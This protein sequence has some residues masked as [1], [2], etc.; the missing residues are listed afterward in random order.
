ML[1]SAQLLD[2][3]LISERKF[4]LVFDNSQLPILI[5]RLSD[6]KIYTVITSFE[7]LFGYSKKE[8]IDK[9]TLEI[10]LWEDI[11]QRQYMIDQMS[12]ALRV[13]DL[14]AVLITKDGRRLICH[15]SCNITQI[16]GE[17]YILNDVYDVTESVHLLEDLKRM[18]THD[19]LTGLAN[20][21]LFY[22]RFDQA[23]ALA[24]RHRFQLAIVMM[25][26]DKLK[27]T[28]DLYGHLIGD[29]A[30]IYLTNQI[31][32]VLRKADTFAR[33]GGDE[34]CIILNEV[35][36]LE[37]IITVVDRIQE[38]LEVPMMIDEVNLLVQVSMGIAVY[39]Q[40]GITVS[41]LIKKADRAMYRVKAKRGCGYLFYHETKTVKD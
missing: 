33:F 6:S 27:E 34:F 18:A 9:T 20:R 1:I 22:D 10:G 35:S 8:L 2:N 38:R 24:Q 25:D 23:Q 30:L 3:V 36:N 19:P 39:P 4:S 13:K 41:D 29:Q 37:D 31:N 28:N 5:T 17:D 26:M 14:Q 7:R 16:L 15:I 32:H 11:S 21:S 12:K 40:D